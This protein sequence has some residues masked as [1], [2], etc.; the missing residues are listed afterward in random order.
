MK[1]LIILT[2]M[3]V[4]GCVG[5]R[6]EDPTLLV[7]PDSV[8][9]IVVGATAPDQ[10][11]KLQF[12][13]YFQIDNQS[14]IRRLVACVINMQKQRDFHVPAIGILSEQRFVD[15]DGVTVLQTHV[16]N[17]KCAVAVM[18][19]PGTGPDYR[20]EGFSVEF[21]Q[22]ILRQMRAHSPEVI[23]TQQDHYR[24][25]GLSLEDLLFNGD[26][27]RKAQ[28]PAGGDGKPAPQP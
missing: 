11:G 19:A 28:P 27:T 14:T 12:K 3:V 18:A 22:E 1:K 24:D 6:I 2:A 13:T 20:T 4:A 16:V 25:M 10:V 21:S 8:H 9:H 5:P 7:R 17:W 15:R 23:K 26:A